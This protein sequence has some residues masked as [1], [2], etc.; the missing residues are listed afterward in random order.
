MADL[1][2]AERR[3]C[4]VCG[5]AATKQVLPRVP[6]YTIR[7]YSD[8]HVERA[9]MPRE[10]TVPQDFCQTHFGEV[11]VLGSRQ[12]GFC[13]RCQ[14]WRPTGG[15]CAKCGAALVRLEGAHGWTI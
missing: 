2:I 4:L 14:A 7:R 1:S 8:A 10:V 3:K 5:D 11:R 12:V 15:P 13:V 9:F 6:E